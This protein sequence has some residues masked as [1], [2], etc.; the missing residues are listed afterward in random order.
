MDHLGQ[1]V[2]SHYIKEGLV[3]CLSM[4]PWVYA[5]FFPVNITTVEVSSNHGDGVGGG[6]GGGTLLFTVEFS[7]ANS[8]SV[9]PLGWR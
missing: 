5:Q 6:G 2:V 9:E 4:W 3:G 8:W 1:M 7:K